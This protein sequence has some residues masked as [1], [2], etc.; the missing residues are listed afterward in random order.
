ME[1]VGRVV[2]LALMLISCASTMELVELGLDGWAIV[3]GLATAG[4]F[5]LFVYG[6]DDVR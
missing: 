2:L 6:G 5:C 1:I 3:S 4:L